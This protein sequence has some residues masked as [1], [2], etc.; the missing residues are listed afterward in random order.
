MGAIVHK[1]SKI[2]NMGEYSTQG[3][4]DQ[5]HEGRYYTK[6]VRSKTWVIIVHKESQIINMGEY[7]IQGE[8]DKKHG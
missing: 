4:S 3:E 8:S 1:E 6:R 7:S 2:K 5:K